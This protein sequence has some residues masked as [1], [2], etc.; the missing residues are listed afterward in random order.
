MREVP[1]VTYV[2]LSAKRSTIHRLT[3]IHVPVRWRGLYDGIRQ[4][5]VTTCGRELLQWVEVSRR[6]DPALRFC[7]RCFKGLERRS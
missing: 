5:M 6:M 2:R 7:M 4:K 3:R 1:L